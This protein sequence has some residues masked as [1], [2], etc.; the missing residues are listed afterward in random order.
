AARQTVFHTI[1]QREQFEA[2][3]ADG[4]ERHG[5]EIHAYCLMT[6]HY[7]LLLHCPDGRLSDFMHHLSSQ[8]TRLVNADLGR[9]G[10]LFRGRFRSLP[11]ESEQYLAAVGRYI[12]RN[13]LDIRPPVVLSQYR[14]SSLRH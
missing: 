13:P 1:D 10:P 12:H 4:H 2:L 9:D 5:V 3:L 6:N 11:I 7:H 14:W 8:Y